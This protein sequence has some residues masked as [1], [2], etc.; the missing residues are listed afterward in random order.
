M[1]HL[2]LFLYWFYLANAGLGQQA[3]PKY[4]GHAIISVAAQNQSLLLHL[5]I[6]EDMKTYRFFL[7]SSERDRKQGRERMGD[8]CSK[9]SYRPGVEPAT[10]AREL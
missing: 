6:L 1:G 2:I 7:F 3:Q 9:G 4:D 10:A 8:T 5:G